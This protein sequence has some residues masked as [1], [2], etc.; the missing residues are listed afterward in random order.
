MD[1]RLQIEDA[2]IWRYMDFAKFAS[3]LT[4]SSLF[5]SKLK[6][7]GDPWEGEWPDYYYEVIKNQ[8][9]KTKPSFQ[10][11]DDTSSLLQQLINGKNIIYD[12]TYVNCW[13]INNY[14]SAAMWKLY[15]LTNQGIALKTTVGKL[16]NEILKRD[17]EFEIRRIEYIDHN[18][19]RPE[20]NNNLSM[21]EPIFYKM[22]AFEYECELRVAFLDKKILQNVTTIYEGEN[23][24]EY[25]NPLPGR[26][27]PIDLAKIIDAI[28]ISP[29]APEWI[30]SVVKSLLEKYGLN[31]KL[32]IRSSMTKYL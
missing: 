14:E 20:T 4:T 17:E 8:I 21:T 2:K 25:K 29:V 27:I 32:V 31:P 9:I 11:K 7:L 12:Y 16:R 26:N 1:S 19:F 6:N 28:H 10:N 18:Y 13:H 23:L 5:F 3:L 30:E 15:S 22:K 24:E